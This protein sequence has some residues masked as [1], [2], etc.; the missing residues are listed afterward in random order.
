MAGMSSGGD[1]RQ[2]R[3]IAFRTADILGRA[4][5]GCLQQER[6]AGGV[7]ILEPALELDDVL[8]IVAEVVEIADGLCP[9]VPDDVVEPGLSCIDRLPARGGSADRGCPIRCRRR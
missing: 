4:A 7:G 8:P 3:S 6:H 2:K 9:D 1:R 5:A